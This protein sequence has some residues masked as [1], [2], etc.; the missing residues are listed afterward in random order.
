MTEL[1]E[2]SDEREDL[3]A[4]A[5]AAIRT[6]GLEGVRFRL[7]SPGGTAV[8]PDSVLNDLGGAGWKNAFRG[9]NVKEIVTV[10]DQ[11]VRCL[12]VR[13][14]VN[15]AYPFVVEV[16][17]PMTDA[18][19]NLRRLLILFLIIIPASVAV[20]ALAAFGITRTAFRPIRGMIESNPPTHKIISERPS[21]PN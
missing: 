3:D 4:R 11:R 8:V 13:A 7:I 21:S 20:L 10:G 9:A 15:D 16:A 17:M 1:E 18:D 6:E 12:W 5:F 2:I 14:E 19:A